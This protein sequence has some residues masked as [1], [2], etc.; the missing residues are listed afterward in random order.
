MTV[1]DPRVHT[2][3]WRDLVGLNRLEVINELTLPLPWFFLSLCFAHFHLYV[4][5]LGFSFIFFLTGLRVVHNAHHYA[6][7]IPQR[8]TEWVMFILSFLMLGSMHA[9]QVNHLRHHLYFMDKEDIEAVSA[10]LKWWQAILI[11]PLFPFLL[12][13]K[14]LSVG[15]R[16][17]VIWMKAELFMS[18][19]MILSAYSLYLPGEFKYHI[20]TMLVGQCLTAF[21][22]VWTVHHDCDR[23][24]Q[25]ARTIRNRIKTLITF[26]MFFHVEHHLFPNVPTCH[27]HRIAERLDAVAPDLCKKRVF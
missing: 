21:F 18:G 11:G 26:S 3:Q 4:I 23:Y 7:G 25:I 15:T 13:H 22:A 10:R 14:A 8:A 17:Q 5:A 20:S 9:V 19:L 1:K 16:R 27:L 6:L 24:N 12:N 2:V